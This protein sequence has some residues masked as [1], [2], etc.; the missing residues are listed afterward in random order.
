MDYQPADALDTALAEWMEQQEDAM[1]NLPTP[2][3]LARTCLDQLA[4][5]V[6][7]LQDELARRQTRHAW[8][9]VH[10]ANLYDQLKWAP[11]ER[12]EL[13]WNKPLS[14][15]RM[16]EVSINH[17]LYNLVILMGIL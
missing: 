16:N 13:E 14:D 6:K 7:M 3:C 2:L 17:Y 10:I 4:Y 5:K 9:C 15:A 12:I 11:E 8:L 1:M